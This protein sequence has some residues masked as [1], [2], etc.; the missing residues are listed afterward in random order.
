MRKARI[1]QLPLAEATPDHPK[2]KVSR[3]RHPVSEVSYLA[4]CTVA[5]ARIEGL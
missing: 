1:Q 4:I 2:A 3:H 5:L